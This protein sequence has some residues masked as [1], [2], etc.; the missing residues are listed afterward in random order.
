MIVQS[1]MVALI[2]MVIIFSGALVGMQVARH[3]PDHHLDTNTKAVVTGSMAVIGTMSALVIGLLISSAN[4]SFTSRNSDVAQLSTDLVRINGFLTRYGAET[5]S[6]RQALREYAAMTYHDLFKRDV[7]GRREVEDTETAKILV[8][9]QDD[10]LSLTPTDNRQRWLSAQALQLA[11]DIGAARALL[12]QQEEIAFP[13]PFLGAVILWLTVLFAS[14][15]LFAPRNATAIIAI[16]LC[17]F[18]VA[19][20]VKLILDMDTPFAGGIHLSR[21]PIRLSSAPI[22]HAIELLNR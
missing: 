22:Q 9:I 10:I 5:D 13:L 4:T 20:A 21:P 7:H 8:T 12:V 11:A 3:L 15:G 18:A 17:A 1:M 16:F 6:A 19:A 2:V 14:Y